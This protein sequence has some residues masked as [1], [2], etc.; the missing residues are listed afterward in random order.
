LTNGT[1]PVDVY[2]VFREGTQGPILVVYDLRYRSVGLGFK[3]VVRK[4]RERNHARKLKRTK[5][6][7]AYA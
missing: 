2:K 6:G 1:S 3:D 4:K 7:D 5:S